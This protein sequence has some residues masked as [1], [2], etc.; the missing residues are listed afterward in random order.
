MWIPRQIELRRPVFD[1]AQR[2]MFDGIETDHAQCEGVPDGAADVCEPKVF[3]QPQH[4]HV[5]ARARLAQ[6]RL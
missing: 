3:E 5:L 1:A 6:P 2:E 4:L